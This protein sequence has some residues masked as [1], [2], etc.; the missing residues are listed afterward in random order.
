MPYA[1]V[2]A[3]ALAG[4]VGRDVAGF[5]SFLVLVVVLRYHY[6]VARRS[7]DCT[8]GLALGLVAVDLLLSLVLATGID[9]LFGI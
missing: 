8:A 5:L 3:L 9:R 4:L 2:S 6:L 1:A 7:L